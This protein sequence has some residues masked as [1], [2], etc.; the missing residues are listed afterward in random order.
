MLNAMIQD[1]LLIG[2]NLPAQTEGGGGGGLFINQLI[3]L[4]LIFGIMWFM[5]IRPAQKERTE[6]EKLRSSLVKGDSV[7]TNGGIHGEVSKTD[8]STVSVRISQNP[9]VEITVE[10]SAILSKVSKTSESEK[11]ES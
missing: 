8:K 9:K 4:M 6:K 3:M 7:V 2:A 1:V 5:L 10:R 11:T